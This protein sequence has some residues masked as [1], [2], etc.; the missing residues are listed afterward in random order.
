MGSV[1]FD[2]RWDRWEACM[3]DKMDRELL[4]EVCRVAT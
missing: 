2:T 1:I 3:G 4:L